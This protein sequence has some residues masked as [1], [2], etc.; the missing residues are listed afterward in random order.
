MERAGTLT[1]GQLGARVRRL[2]LSVDPTSAQER[3]ERGIEGRRVE[4]SAN[5]DGTAN[6]IAYSLPAE[7]ANAAYHR[8]DHLALAAKG[9]DDPRSL[10]QV[11][12]DVLIDLLDTGTGSPHRGVIDLRVDLATLTGL[13]EDPGEV[14]ATGRWWPTWPAR[15]PPPRWARSGGSPSPTPTAE[16]CSGTGPPSGDPAPPNAAMSRRGLSP[17]SP[18]VPDAR[19]PLRPGPPGRPLPGGTHLVEY[20]NPLCRHDHR[21]KDAGWKLRPGPNGTTT[22]TSPLGH[23][24]TIGP[25]PP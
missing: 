16:R 3:Y 5:P 20:L 17:V 22:W 8:L 11:R 23:T 13:A 19:H 7:R 1:T 4:L 10:D 2:V 14:P 12:A 15:W 6:L 21:L 25:D 9:P 24:Y 18:R